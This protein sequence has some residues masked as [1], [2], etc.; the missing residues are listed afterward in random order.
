MSQQKRILVIDSAASSGG[1]MTVLKDFYQAVYQYGKAANWIFL[2]SDHYI[3]SD[4]NIKVVVRPDL[5]GKMKRLAFDAGLENGFLD[6]IK[7]D[8]IFSL[9]NTVPKYDQAYKILYVH[10]SLPFQ[11]V[12][13]FSFL[14]KEEQK[15]AT[16]Q[17]LLGAFIKKSINRSDEVIVQ[18]KWMKKA[19]LSSCRLQET[20]VHQIYPPVKKTENQC[21]YDHTNQFFYPGSSQSY[22]NVNLLKEACKKLNGKGYKYDVYVTI[23]PEEQINNLHYIGKIS[24]DEVMERY[25]KSCLVF[26]S[27]IETF[28]YPLVEAKSEGALILASDCSF[29]HELLDGYYNAYFFR[30]D[31]CSD[32]MALMERI[33]NGN[34]VRKNTQLSTEAYH[35]QTNENTWKKIIELLVTRA[36]GI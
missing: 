8:L 17:Y 25:S 22:K 23:E 13:K 26:P 1:A 24:H 33:L 28:G 2:L 7:P 30:Y 6:K 10:Q 4:K 34:I 20:K 19:V 16:I 36:E 11:T 18:T 29:S 35:E 27:Y 5:K 15:E 31:S 3:E 32:L 12:K 9:Q 21:E 14:K